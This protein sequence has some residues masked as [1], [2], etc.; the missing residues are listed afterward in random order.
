MPLSIKYASLKT[1]SASTT[2]MHLIGTA[3]DMFGVHL[4][5]NG[6]SSNDLYLT[7]PGNW[8]EILDMVGQARPDPIPSESYDAQ[9]LEFT[10]LVTKAVNE[11]DVMRKIFPL[12]EGSCNY[13]TSGHHEFSNLEDLTNGNIAKASPDVYDGADYREVDEEILKELSTFIKPLKNTKTPVLPN[14]FAEIKGP[15]AAGA[16]AE[17]Q[18][19]Y[20]GAIGSRAIHAL[21]S[22]AIENPGTVYDNNAYTITAIYHSKTIELN[23]HRPIEPSVPGG[24]TRYKMSIIGRYSL[25]ITPA[26]FRDGVIAFRNA[27]EWAKKKRDEFIAE[28]NTRKRNVAGT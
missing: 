27:R 18:A 12:I 7:Q 5:D 13:D 24:P 25:D 17:Q 21:R 22:I 2:E 20:D 1:A 6:V 11:Q 28:A 9:F 14:F 10:R 26:S 19:R 8:Q 4:G 15:K 23:A 16:T 3:N